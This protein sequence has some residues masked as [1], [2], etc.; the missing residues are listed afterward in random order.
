MTLLPIRGTGM[1]QMGHYTLSP[2]Q[3]LSMAH[4]ATTTPRLNLTTAPY[5]P[6]VFARLRP[7]QDTRDSDRSP[8]PGGS[9]PRTF[10]QHP[11]QAPFPPRFNGGHVKG[12]AK[13]QDQYEGPSMQKG[14]KNRKDR[15]RPA[16]SRSIAAADH[17]GTQPQ[18]DPL[19]HF[20]E[21]MESS[22]TNHGFP[23]K[24]LYKDC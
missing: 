9:G 17:T 18:Q 1:Q 3:P 6:H 4:E 23:F 11:Q 12:K 21:L 20:H 16:N 5:R 14:K 2:Q 8:S 15:R 22:C 7:N 24:H 10:V 13:C 19:G